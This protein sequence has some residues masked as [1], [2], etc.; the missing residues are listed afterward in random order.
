MNIDLT[1]NCTFLHLFRQ[2]R[3]REP[4]QHPH[5]VSELAYARSDYDGHQWWH[6]WQTVNPDYSLP[7]VVEEI[8][9]FQAALFRKPEFK[10]LKALRKF[11]RDNAEPTSDSTEFNLYSE[12]GNLYI[13]LRLITRKKDYNVYAHYYMKALVAAENDSAEGKE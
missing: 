1:P 4:D 13:W 5:P 8:D 10:D 11:C 6:T 7:P 2:T 12:S 9:G 3:K